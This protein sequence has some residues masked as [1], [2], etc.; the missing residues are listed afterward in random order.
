MGAGVEGCAI[1]LFLCFN[2]CVHFCFTYAAAAKVKE[3][4]AKLSQMEKVSPDEQRLYDTAV[5]PAEKATWLIA[6]CEAQ[7]CI[8]L[9]FF[10]LIFLPLPQSLSLP[11]PAAPPA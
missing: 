11:P 1:V 9:Y 8:L 5:D 7:V 4:E 6:M 10:L 3:V 2:K